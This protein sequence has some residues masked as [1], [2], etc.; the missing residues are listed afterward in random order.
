MPVKSEN[1]CLYLQTANKKEKGED[2]KDRG[3]RQIEMDC[4]FY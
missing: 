3:G 2:R 1:V 4:C